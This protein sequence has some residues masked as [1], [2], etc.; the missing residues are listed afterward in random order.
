MAPVVQAHA[1]HGIAGLQKA[2]VNRHVGLGTAVGLH[3]G[4]IRAVEFLGPFDGDPFH[5]VH[6]AAAA[7]VPASR[8]AFRVFIG[9][10]AAHGRHD[11][12]ADKV[13]RS[14]QFN[15]RFLTGAFSG[16]GLGY[17]GVLIQ[18]GGQIPHF[19]ILQYKKYR[20]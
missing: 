10:W 11:S 1:Q 5:L 15:V 14:D 6:A 19:V 17:L 20:V 13:F 3:V 12:G 2:E 4:M 18:A 9:Q 8:I 16:D 7:V